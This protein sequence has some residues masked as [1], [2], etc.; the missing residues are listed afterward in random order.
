MTDENVVPLTARQKGE[1]DAAKRFGLL[2]TAPENTSAPATARELGE[3]AASKRFSR[4][5][6]V[7]SDEERLRQHGA[8]SD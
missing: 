1:R 2:Y 4:P 6:R 5:L 7:V 3:L 8:L